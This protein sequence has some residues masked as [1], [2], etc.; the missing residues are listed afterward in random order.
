VAGEW[1]TYCPIL[2]AELTQ[3]Y[4]S[5]FSDARYHLPV[6]ISGWLCAPGASFVK[7]SYM[8]LPNRTN[9]S[10]GPILNTK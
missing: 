7:G 3:L 8:W 5:G 6:V 4:P 10:K 2:H 9:F 1:G